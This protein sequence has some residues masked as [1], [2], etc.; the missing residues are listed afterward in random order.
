MYHIC[1]ISCMYNVYNVNNTYILYTRMKVWGES[2]ARHTATFKNRYLWGM[3]WGNFLFSL[4]SGA[5]QRT[6][7]T[8]TIKNK[9]GVAG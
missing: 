5:L 3:G 6:W 2:W 8:L 4:I 9:S 7:I 1:Y